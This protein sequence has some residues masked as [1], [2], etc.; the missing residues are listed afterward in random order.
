MRSFLIKNKL[1]ISLDFWWE[2]IG[3]ENLLGFFALKNRANYFK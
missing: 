1:N 2:E 3:W